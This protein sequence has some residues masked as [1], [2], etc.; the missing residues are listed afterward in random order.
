MRKSTF[1]LRNGLVLL[2]ICSLVPLF[3]VSC[4][5]D[6][7]DKATPD[8][9]DS[10]S[11]TKIE[12]LPADPH[13]RDEDGNVVS[14]TNEYTFFRFS[15]SSIVANSDSATDK[16]DIGFRST[17]VILNGG[18]NG[19]GNVE[20]QVVKSVFEEVATAPE[21]GYL[22]DTEEGNVFSEWYNY[23]MTKHIIT[24]EPGYILVIHTNDDKYV[25]VEILS[26]YKN[27]PSEITSDDAS[28]YYTFRYVVQQDGSKSFTN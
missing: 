7:D 10:V 5:K 8:D 19:P 1:N 25:K 14:G 26:Y 3:M 12:N 22:Q 17:S 24:P 9:Q 16:W 28:G 2:V 20:G 27:N 18:V 4:S 11:V 23:N 6:N 13:I 15:D 21:K